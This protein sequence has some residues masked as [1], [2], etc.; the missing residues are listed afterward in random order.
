MAT[1]YVPVSD[2][3]VKGPGSH[4]VSGPPRKNIAQPYI[5][6]G[7]NVPGA[8]VPKRHRLMRSQMEAIHGIS[9]QQNPLSRAEHDLRLILPV[10]PYLW[11]S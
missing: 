3:T 9:T 6:R 8:R 4:Q 2:A 7:L 5:S 10:H 11:K 1:A